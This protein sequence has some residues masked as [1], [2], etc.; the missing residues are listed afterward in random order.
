MKLTAVKRIKERKSDIKRTRN[1]G[2]IPGVLYAPGKSS[3][4]MNFAKK[5]F[6]MA[7]QGIPSGRLSTTV[8]SL[9]F[10]GKEKKVIVKDIQYDKTTY[11]VIH[12]DFEELNSKTHVRV[13]VPV[14]CTGTMDCVGVKSGGFV[15]Q[16]IRKVKVKCL[17]KDIPQEFSLDVTALDIGHSK[18]CSDIDIP[19][20]VNLLGKKEEIVVVVAKK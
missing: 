6:Q 9:E 7:L 13:N 17:P 18:R 19:K 8:F 16:I 1:E 4:T 10:D 2:F 15:R 3:E 14:I 12:V 20:G 5:D 11:D